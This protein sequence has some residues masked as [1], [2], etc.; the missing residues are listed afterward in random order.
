MKSNERVFVIISVRE[1]HK[2]LLGETSQ[3]VIEFDEKP[4]AGNNERTQLYKRIF[5][6]GEEIRNRSLHRSSAYVP[7][8]TIRNNINHLWS[9]LSPSTSRK[10]NMAEI[11]M[12]TTG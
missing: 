6:A 5:A 2:E 11:R 9:Y 12:T 7:S 10:Q 3:T 8:V 1:D 4:R